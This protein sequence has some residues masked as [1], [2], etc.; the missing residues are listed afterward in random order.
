MREEHE[1]VNEIIRTL[2]E[3]YARTGLFI[4]GMED[5][6]LWITNTDGIDNK[7]VCIEFNSSTKTYLVIE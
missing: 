2:N 6:L 7:A 3:S 5:G 1:Y 4:V